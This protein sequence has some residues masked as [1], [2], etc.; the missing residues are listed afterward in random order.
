MKLV[1]LVLVFIMTA[2]NVFPN[3]IKESMNSE[4]EQVG[5]GRETS[6]IIGRVEVYGNEPRT[7]VGIVDED[8]VEYAVYPP[9]KEAELRRLQGNLIKF[10]VVFVEENIFAS[11]FLK[12][13]TVEPV[14]WEILD[15]D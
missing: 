7:F 2:F 3:G 1:F 6:I 8:G 13:G 11:M 5:A 4:V 12:G 14:S 10:T 15:G 9:A